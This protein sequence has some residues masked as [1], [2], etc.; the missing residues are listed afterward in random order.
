MAKYV[1]VPCAHCGKDFLRQDIC[2][3]QKWCSPYCRVMT[4]IDQSSVDGC[5]EFIGSRQPFGYGVINDHGKILRTHRVVFEWH[6]GPIP[7]GMVV[8]HKCDNGACCRI[9]HLELG[10]KK[11]NTQDMLS[12]KRH[13][14]NP[15]RGNDRYNAKLDEQKVR[16]IRRM[17]AA[18]VRIKDIADAFGISGA[19]AHV[20]ATKKGWTH[21]T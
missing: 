21:V 15:E 14:T 17:Y 18:G 20:V 5:W 19:N 4:K 1:Y 13:R 7:E 9:D 3:A 11:D 8:R 6:F 12:R 10:T 16:E 2:G